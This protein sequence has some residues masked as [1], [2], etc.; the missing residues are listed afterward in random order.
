[1][2]WMI[3]VCSLVLAG[4]GTSG[5]IRS[6]YSHVPTDRFTYEVVN[7][8]EMSVEGLVILRARL[9][10]TL[11]ALG[12]LA[13]DKDPAAKKIK[14]EITEY[15]MR[16]GATRALFGIMAGRDTIISDVRVFSAGGDVLGEIEINSRN[17]SAWGT[18]HGLIEQHADEIVGFVSGA[19]M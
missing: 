8:G 9:D 19:K 11:A 14:I 4:C 1:M 13:V 2:K 5:Q 7:A 16:N 6:N 10:S 18:S 3:V 17:A 15:R 12:R